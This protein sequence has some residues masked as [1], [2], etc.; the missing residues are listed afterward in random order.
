MDILCEICTK[1]FIQGPGLS[2]KDCEMTCVGVN[3]WKCVK[4]SEEKRQE[5]IDLVRRADNFATE[6]TLMPVK[7]DKKL[8]FMPAPLVGSLPADYE[9]ELYDPREVTVLVPRDPDAIDLI[10]EEACE[11][12]FKQRHELG[13]LT[14]FLSKRFIFPSKLTATLTILYRKKLAEI[15][16]DRVDLLTRMQCTSKGPITSR[17][18]RNFRKK[19]NG[20]ILP[21][22]L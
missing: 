21:S 7:I 9:E 16:K 18:P 1:C 15:R 8:V 4:C 6:D 10:T 17:N 14:A 5:E 2:D 20:I 3:S 11:R 13:K 12:A 19:I 22:R